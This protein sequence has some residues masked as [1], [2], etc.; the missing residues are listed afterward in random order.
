MCVLV[1]PEARPVITGL[2]SQMVSWSGSLQVSLGSA[3][4]IER[5]M[6]VR[7]GSST[8]SFAS[9]QRAKE[10]DFKQ[11]S[12]KLT[13][14]AP[15]SATEMPPGYYML[16]VFQRNAQAPADAKRLVPSQARII[17]LG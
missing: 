14:S 1:E 8:H 5:V 4:A 16:F 17:K 13:V 2:S 3:T 10:L 6:L 9:E 15:A 12:Q 7:T 11:D